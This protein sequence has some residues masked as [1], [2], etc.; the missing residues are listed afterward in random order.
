MYVRMYVCMYVCM[1]E[2]MYVCMLGEA[3]I[4]GLQVQTAA[5]L[6]VI[7]RVVLVTEIVTLIDGLLVVCGEHNRPVHLIQSKEK[8]RISYQLT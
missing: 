5:C 4:Y 6:L 2:C 7:F 3:C 8:I 1:Y